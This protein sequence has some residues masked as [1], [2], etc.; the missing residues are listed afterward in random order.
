MSSRSMLLALAAVIG[1]LTVTRAI[2]Q[3]SLQ[4]LWLAGWLPAVLVAVCIPSRRRQT[5]KAAPGISDEDD[6]SS[7]P[8]EQSRR[9]R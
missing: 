7:P 9:T 6:S 2:Q 3:Q 8:R 5:R 1:G 4:P